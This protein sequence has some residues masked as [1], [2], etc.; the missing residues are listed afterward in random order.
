MSDNVAIDEAEPEVMFDGLHHS[1]RAHEPRDDAPD[2]ALARRRATARTARITDI[3]NTREAWIIFAVNPDGAEYDIGAGTFHHWRKNR[4]PNAGT[5]AIGTDLNRNYGYRWGSGG[6]TSSSPRPSR[7]EGRAAF[8]APETRAVRDFLAARVV[9]GR[10]QIR[11]SISF[12]EFG[13]ATSCGRTATRRPNLPSDM[14]S[15][16]RA[17]LATIGKAHGVHER[18]RGGAGERPL[19]A[20]GTSRD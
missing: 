13:A 20:S 15:Q 8:S 3:V 9:G 10:Q 19:P 16:D 12:H 18:L 6:R 4:Q 5:T 14:T 2:P 1:A 11:A 17:A 7:T